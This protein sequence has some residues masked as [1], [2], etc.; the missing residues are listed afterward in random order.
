MKTKVSL[1]PDVISH[2]ILT[3][4]ANHAPIDGLSFPLLINGEVRRLE[5]YEEEKED[6]IE[7][8]FS[9]KGEQLN[10]RTQSGCGEACETVY[11]FDYCMDE[12]LNALS[13]FVEVDYNH[14]LKAP[15][16]LLT[17]QDIMHET[18]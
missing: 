7:I 11:Q 13:G 16:D 4:V 9:I 17:N 3:M 5:C 6:H 2:M 18:N 15:L 10:S 14:G 12:M 1:T 8:T